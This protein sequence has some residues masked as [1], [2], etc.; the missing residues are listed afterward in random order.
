[1]TK[2]KKKTDG[3]VPVSSSSKTTWRQTPASHAADKK[4]NLKAMKSL[5]AKERSL[6]SSRG[7]LPWGATRV[8]GKATATSKTT[9]SG[10]GKSR[11]KRT[12]DGPGGMK[13]SWAKPTL[14]RVLAKKKK[15]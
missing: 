13:P 12:F 1:M 14:K 9:H 11:T 8:G 10:S 7:E 15:K 3:G 6:L 5:T 4:K 2:V